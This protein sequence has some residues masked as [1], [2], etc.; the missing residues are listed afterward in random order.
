MESWLKES[1]AIGLNDLEIADFQVT[2]RGVRSLQYFKEG[3]TV[4]TIPSGILWKV[5][6]AYADPLLGPALRSVQPPLTVED[7]LATYILFVRSRKSGYNGLRSHVT[8]LPTSYSS[9]I[10]FTENELKVCAGTSLYIV[11]Q[12]L[13]QQIEEDYAGLVARIFGQHRDLFPLDKFTIEDYKWALSTVWSRGMDFVLPDGNSIRLMAPFAD[14]LNHSPEVKQCHLYDASSG[15][16]SVLAGKDYKV[17]DQVFINYGPLPNNR[18]LRLYGFVLSSNPNDSYDLVLSTQ[19]TAPFWEQKQ[20]LWILAGLDSTCT[21]SLT[22]TDPLPKNVLRYL[23]IQRLDESDLSVIQVD[24]TDGII[25]A[26]NEV[27]VLQFLGDSLCHLLENFGNQLEILEEQLAASV[28]P[29]GGN[30]WAAAHVSLGEQRVLRS[31]RKR[32]EDLLAA[33]ESGRGRRGDLPS[34][35]RCANCDNVSGPLMLC[36]RCKAV[37]YCTRTCQVAHHKEHKVVCRVKGIASKNGS[38]MG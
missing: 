27:E 13:K 10:F 25:N 31:A 37:S 4:L 21:I 14:M 23:R 12:Q 7:T 1:G 30:A 3:E 17:G 22:L 20:K 15:N 38:E 11:T 34:L 32:A 18:L 36:G 33:A 35:A 24:A 28:H 26:S 2:G 19:P 29:P 5:E 6:H 8:A 16:L 9:S